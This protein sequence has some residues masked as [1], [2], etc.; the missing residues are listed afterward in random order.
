MSNVVNVLDSYFDKLKKG[1]D[2]KAKAKKRSAAKVFEESKPSKK[3][4]TAMEKFR[5]KSGLSE[6]GLAKVL[7]TPPRKDKDRPHLYVNKSNTVHQADLLFLS[8]DYSNKNAPKKHVL[9]VVD[10]HSRL[11]DAEPLSSKTSEGVL[12]AFKAIYRRKILNKPTVMIIVD[13]GT[14]F[15][16]KVTPHFKGIVIKRGKPGRSRQQAMV[17]SHNGMI[18]KMIAELQLN[19]ELAT[20]EHS[21]FWAESL[22]DFV[23]PAINEHFRE[24][25]DRHE[26]QLQ[27]VVDADPTCKGKSCELLKKG[28]RVRVIAEKPVDPVTGKR[29]GAKWRQGDLRWEKQIRTVVQQIIKPGNPPLYRVSSLA[30]GKFN[31]KQVAHT[32]AQLK[33]VD[34]DE[35]SV[36]VKGQQMFRV[37]YILPAQPK[38]IKGKKHVKVRWEGL[39]STSDTWE[40]LSVLQADAPNE[41]KIWRAKVKKRT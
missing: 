7:T 23:I 9:V 27:E 2:K 21:T 13:S 29:L 19:T 5:V 6:K 32:K 10:A 33:V 20:G 40:P 8:T 22:K 39:G 18:S 3:K 12:K 24:T 37:D 1:D 17:E 31:M 16:G 28:T 34:P 4:Q 38:I 11:T 35:E 30:G 36:S 26:H 41:V 25:S 14:E 15:K